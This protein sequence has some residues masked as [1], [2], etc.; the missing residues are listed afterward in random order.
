MKIKKN[1]EPLI[2]GI[3]AAIVIGILAFLTIRTSAGVS[4]M[5]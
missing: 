5:F 3:S 2:S 1:L 4:L